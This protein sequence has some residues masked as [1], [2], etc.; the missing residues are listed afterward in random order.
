M[1]G[2]ISDSFDPE[3]GTS[4]VADEISDSLSEMYSL[5]SAIIERGLPTE[6]STKPIDIRVLASSPELQTRITAT[7]TEQQWR[8]LRFA[9]ERAKESL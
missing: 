5:V 8:L 3:W 4:S 1:P 9:L 2:P 6:A 7:L